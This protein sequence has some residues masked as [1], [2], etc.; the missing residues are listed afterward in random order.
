MTTHVLNTLFVQS[1]GAYL[2]LDHE[3]VRVDVDGEQRLQVPLRQL[4]GVAVFGNVLVS[5]FLVHRLAQDGRDLTWFDQNGEFQA[6]LC[7]PTS[8]NVLLRKAQYDAHCDLCR[9]LKLA[10]RMVEGKIRNARYVLQRAQRDRPEPSMR[11]TAAIHALGDCL[12][13]LSN[14]SDVDGVRGVEGQAAAAYFDAFGDML[15]VEGFSFDQRTRR[16]PRDPVNALLSFLYALL[17]R[18]CAAALEGIGLDPQVGYLHT[19]RPGR[20]AL[21]LDLMEEF[22]SW[23]AD[24][25]T[26]SL[27]NRRQVTPKHFD[28]RPGGAVYLNEA[29]R[30]EVITAYQRRKQETLTY[31][32]LKQ[33]VPVGLVPQVQARLLA[34]VLR[35]DLPDYAPFTPK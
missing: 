18:D 8:G 15:L 4:D 29:G 22:R 5:P 11:L 33:E 34:R 21:A 3:T 16:P 30:R 12:R 19:V 28:E 13:L 35:G 14:A 10:V 24:R 25:L 7:G 2:R 31:P 27:V 23:L 32:L 17:I 6:R 1:Q 20:P 26:L 9:T